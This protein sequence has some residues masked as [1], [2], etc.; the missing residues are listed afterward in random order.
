[1]AKRKK[2][3][4][5]PESKRGPLASKA[6]QFREA[7]DENESHMAEMAAMAVTCEQFGIDEEEGYDLLV[8][9]DSLDNGNN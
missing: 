5:E 2:K 9:A 7:L 3:Q 4:I 1:M 6:Q 8:E